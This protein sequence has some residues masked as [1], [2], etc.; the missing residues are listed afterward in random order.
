MEFAIDQALK[1]Y[2]GGLG[3]LAGSHMRS[4]YDLKQNL[5]GIG[6]LWKYGYYEQTRKGHGEMDVLHRERFYNFLQDTG[7]T[8]E[9]SLN[10]APV[11]VKAWYLA[12]E[13]FG[14]APVFL[15]STDLPE[16]D[17]LAQT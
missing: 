4:A 8:F 14:T 17:W 6:V 5:V 7:I 13:V 12:P 1:I 15:L 9:I 11:K 10:R 16:N 2:S 3:Y